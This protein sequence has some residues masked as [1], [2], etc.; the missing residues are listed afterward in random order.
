MNVETC[1]LFVLYFVLLIF[2]IYE[3]LNYGGISNI[4][5][6]LGG[7][8]K[9]GYYYLHANSQIMWKP[10]GVVDIDPEYFNSPY[11]IKYWRVETSLEY[12]DMMIEAK[13]IDNG[14]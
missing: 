11:V 4:A 3:N 7:K 1:M 13:N 12:Q 14:V 6:W 10:F 5:L 2:H 9:P 8:L